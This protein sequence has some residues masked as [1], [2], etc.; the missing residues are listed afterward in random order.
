[1]S[2]LLVFI[3]DGTFDEGTLA[4]LEKATLILGSTLLATL[5]FFFLL[6]NKEYLKTF[7]STDT[8]Q[9]SVAKIFSEGT[10]VMKKSVFD[11]NLH[12]WEPIKEDVE[13]WVAMEWHKWEEEKP[14]WFNDI[15]KES[16]PGEKHKQITSFAFI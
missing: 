15:W 14:D 3:P 9:Q 5:T 4:I 6:I 1:M 16:V 8:A 13:H 7:L 10:D 12:H 11:L 2:L